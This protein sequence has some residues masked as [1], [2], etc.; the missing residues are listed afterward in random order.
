MK[1]FLFLILALLLSVSTATAQPYTGATRNVATRFS[2]WILNSTTAKAIAAAPTGL[3]CEVDGWADGTT[4]DGYADAA[5]AEATVGTAG[6]FYVL[7]TAGEMNFDYVGIRCSASNTNA[8]D[9]VLNIDTR[10][11]AVLT[12]SSGQLADS[13][14]RPA[15]FAA[16]GTAQSVTGTTIRL[17]SAETFA[18][19]ELNNNTS[20][21]INSASTGAGQTRCVTDYVSSTDT[22]TV[23]TW[24]TTPTGTITYDLIA[25]PNCN[26]STGA[27]ADA[28]WDEQRSGHTTP[29]SFGQGMEIV[30]RRD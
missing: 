16:R 2:G 26:L 8:T 20:V 10:H 21:Y 19:D 27:V 6:N 15:S 4:G 30:P 18:D 24:T 17:A 28:V 13:T 9:W 14:I 25:T 23:P 12:N 22:A 1:K 5:T 11:G 3:D 7:L 29:G